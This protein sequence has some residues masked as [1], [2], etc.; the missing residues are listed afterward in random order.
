MG[1]T[2]QLH[3]E[4]TTV[5]T[6]MQHSD[7]ANSPHFENQAVR[8]AEILP[9]QVDVDPVLVES[10]KPN[11]IV[12][13]DNQTKY[14]FGTALGSCASFGQRSVGSVDTDGAVDTLIQGKEG[15]ATPSGEAV[16]DS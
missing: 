3:D 7:D 13:P 14:S 11:E 10:Q 15:S 9:V 16:A 2:M 5:S 4:T 6:T 12:D 8:S 1:S